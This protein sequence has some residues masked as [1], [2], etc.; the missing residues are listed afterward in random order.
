M[1]N[2]K[3]RH[4]FKLTFEPLSNNNTVDICYMNIHI[5]NWPKPQPVI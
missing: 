5:T 1:K 3:T 2:K 4:I